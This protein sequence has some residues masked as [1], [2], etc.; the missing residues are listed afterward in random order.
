MSQD[1]TV[2]L[3]NSV[4]A[5]EVDTFKNMTEL[6]FSLKSNLDADEFKL[7]KIL[8]QIFDKIDEVLGTWSQNCYFKVRTKDATTF[9]IVCF[10]GSV[11]VFV[12]NALLQM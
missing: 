4:A 5:M 10:N 8:R 2:Y 11:E 6:G 7:G 9:D 1:L 3:N 12:I